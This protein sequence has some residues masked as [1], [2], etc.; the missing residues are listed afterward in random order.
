MVTDLI[1]HVSTREQKIA[2]INIKLLKMFVF[3][4]SIERKGKC[5]NG[6]FIQP[7]ASLKTFIKQI[8]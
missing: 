8:I 7:V 2:P 3:L 4:S 6:T 5:K 1:L